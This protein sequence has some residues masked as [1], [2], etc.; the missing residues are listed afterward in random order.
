M[1]T[2]PINIAKKTIE[3][4][5]PWPSFFL[6]LFLWNL[7]ARKGQH[8]IGFLN[9]LNKNTMW[10]GVFAFLIFFKGWWSTVYV[11]RS[12]NQPTTSCSLFPRLWH[13]FILPSNL[14]SDCIAPSRPQTPRPYLNSFPSFIVNKK[15]SSRWKPEGGNWNFPAIK[16]D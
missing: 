1:E 9:T 12:Q 7:L 3:D 10:S 4:L 16:T 2:D 5:I 8:I 14:N 11:M 6:S 15:I 13:F